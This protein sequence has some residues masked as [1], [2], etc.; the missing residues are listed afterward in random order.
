LKLIKTYKYKLRPNKT[1]IAT[2]ES[3]LGINR[4]L[5][6]IALEHRITAYQSNKTSISKFEQYNQLKEC[7]D[8][9][10]LSFLKLVHSQVLQETLDRVDKAFK[11][12][13][14]GSGFPRFQKKG[15]YNSF[16]FKQGI[17]LE[18][19]KIRLPK[20][21][22]VR[23][24]NSR[25]FEGK[26]KTATIIK[27]LDSWY[28]CIT[29]EEQ[30]TIRLNSQEVGIDM[31]VAKLATLSNGR[32]IEN[33]KF[34]SK[35]KSKIRILNRKLARQKKGSNLRE[36]TKSKL[37]KT[38]QKLRRCR[39]DYI[40]KATTNIT[41]EYGTIYV[42]DLKLSNMTKSAKGNS[43]KPGKNVKAKSGLNRSL[44][45]SSIGI[46][47]NQLEYKTAF[48]S[49]DFQKVNPQYTSQTCCECGYKSKNNRKTQ[50]KF[51]CLDCGHSDNADINAAK[52]IIGL[53][54][55]KSRQRGA[56]ARA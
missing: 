7:K 12:F 22:F 15:F 13:F 21:G 28:V 23:F 26:I 48:K 41:N 55:S 30:P 33:P 11:N 52:N 47:L 27:E 42:E 37:A 35:F 38:Y 50:S 24:F 1:Q 45:D 3:W 25:R 2:F 40:H 14:R 20:I 39:L 18:C 34:L 56:L 19:N 10:E 6:N 4:Y 8:T 44:L 54:K 51:E 17:R 31:G 32:V 36:K 16:T 49:G 9:A 29:V 53:G 5:Y 43:E 46:F